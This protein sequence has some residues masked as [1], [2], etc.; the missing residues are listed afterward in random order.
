MLGLFLGGSC[1]SFRFLLADF[2]F[3]G[4]DVAFYAG[5]GG[6]Q[7]LWQNDNQLPLTERRRGIRKCLR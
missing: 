5:D 3:E 2:F 6:L 7:G 4:L 1:R